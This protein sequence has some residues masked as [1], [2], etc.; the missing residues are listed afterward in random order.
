[1]IVLLSSSA[2][3]FSSVVW[4]Y[5]RVQQSLGHAVAEVVVAFLVILILGLIV[6]GF[7]AGFGAKRVLRQRNAQ[8]LRIYRSL[9]WCKIFQAF[10]GC[11]GPQ[12]ETETKTNSH[13]QCIPEITVLLDRPPRRG[14]TPMHTIDRWMKVVAAWE[15]RDPLYNT[16]TLQE[17]LGEQFGTYADGSPCMSESSYY[18]WRKK[19]F[20]EWRKREDTKKNVVPG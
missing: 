15:N 11:L 7:G 10:W 3:V 8:A 4:I 20:E 14:R 13:E 19:V 9:K 6:A 17:F 16:M 5:H 18:E 1:M 2:G 12:V